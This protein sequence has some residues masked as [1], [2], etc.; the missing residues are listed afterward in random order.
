MHMS[1]YIR[2]L[3]LSLTRQ[4][5]DSKHCDLTY[6]STGKLAALEMCGF[7][8]YGRPSVP[9]EALPRDVWLGRISMCVMA[10]V[11]TLPLLQ[12]PKV[13]NATTVSG[14]IVMGLGP[15]V[16]FCGIFKG[17]RPLAFHV[18]FWLGAVIG[19]T[20]QLS[21]DEPGTNIDYSSFAIGSGSYAGLLGV[22]LYGAIMCFAVYFICLLENREGL[23]FPGAKRRWVSI[24]QDADDAVEAHKGSKSAAVSC[25]GSNGYELENQKTV[26]SDGASTAVGAPAV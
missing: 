13:L 4:H 22:N 23:D 12:D 19:I 14:T 16:I 15:P 8:R 25:D 1:S 7:F 10:V 17:Y 2:L 24:G 6:F 20:Y 26:N 21:I 5:D 9:S 18:P 3:L 11:G